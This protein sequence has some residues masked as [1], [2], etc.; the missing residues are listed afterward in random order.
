MQIKANIRISLLGDFLETLWLATSDVF[1]GMLALRDMTGF[2]RD[3]TAENILAEQEFFCF[4][5]WDWR[6]LK[7]QIRVLK[8]LDK[9]GANIWVVFAIYSVHTFPPAKF[10]HFFRIIFFYLLKHHNFILFYFIAFL[11]I[12]IICFFFP[13]LNIVLTCTL[14]GRKNVI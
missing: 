4:L 7:E 13:D 1:K 14:I 6:L 12:I 3:K 10:K 9:G 5:F 11:E 2:M 8:C